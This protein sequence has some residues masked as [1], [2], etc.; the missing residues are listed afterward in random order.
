M[1]KCFIPFIILCVLSLGCSQIRYSQPVILDTSR[2]PVY[3]RSSGSRIICLVDNAG[4]HEYDDWFY[5]TR[6]HGK[7]GG[8][9]FVS[10]QLTSESNSQPESYVGWV[11]IEK[12]EVFPLCDKYIGDHPVQYLY[13]KANTKEAKDSLEFNSYDDMKMY[14]LIDFDRKSHRVKVRIDYYGEIHCG[15]I[16]RY[17][18]NV[19]NSCN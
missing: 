14:E 12:C 5:E 10:I 9:Y 3:R 7:R 16:D 15:W 2:I 6:I 18:S 19:N 1:K 8:R 11:D 4:R 17:C 13:E